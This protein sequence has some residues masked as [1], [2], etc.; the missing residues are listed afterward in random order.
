[1][2]L[3]SSPCSV[4]R[5]RRGADLEHWRRGAAAPP[6]YDVDVSASRVAFARLHHVPE[7]WVAIGNHVSPMVGVV[8]SAI[9]DRSHVIV[10]VGEFTSVTFPWM[11]QARRGVT[12][13]EVELGA[14]A[15]AVDETTS[16]VAVSSVQSAD[17][18]RADLDAIREATN[19]VGAR[20]LVDTTQS[21]GWLDLDVSAFD[22]TVCAA[23]K[24][25]L[26][27]RG[28]AVMVVRPDLWEE[29]TPTSAGW[30]AGDDIWDSIYGAPLRLA[31]TARRFDVS[32][33]PC[34]VGTRAALSLLEG[35]GVAAIEAHDLS[36]AAAAADALGS[37]DPR[38]GIAIHV[39][40]VDGSAG[41]L[42]RH[43]I[44]AALRNGR[45]RVSFHLYN[46]LD[47]VDALVSAVS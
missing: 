15:D 13:T 45:L 16:W 6:D 8:A 20:M 30:Y 17:G 23:Y 42:A 18:R 33:W 19:R 25:L 38:S 35:V 24:W 7:E 1:M 40:H 11:A 21:A 12:V 39:S 43:G 36:L 34:W 2:S 31:S 37:A 46:T 5:R 29:L 44:R 41:R 26:S 14:L 9:P 32:A 28:T 4:A 27:P 22:V 47:D 3:W 10:P